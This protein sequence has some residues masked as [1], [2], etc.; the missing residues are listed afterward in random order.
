[1]ITFKLIRKIGKI[2]RGGAG[3]KEIMLGVVCGVILGFNPSVN[4]TLFLGILLTLLLNANISF[5]LF[6][7][8][9]GRLASLALAPAS[10]HL[11]IAII[12]DIGL[13][14]LFRTLANAPVTALM[15]L[16]VYA[17]VGGFPIALTIGIVLGAALGTSVIRIRKKMLEANQH[18]II[19]KT[20]GSRVSR[21]L[22]WLAFGK[23][24]LS[25]D[26]E[27][28]KKSPLFRKSGIIFVAALVVIGLLLELVLFDSL[29]RKGIETSISAMTGAE[30]NIAKVD[31]S[32]ANGKVDIQKLEA[33]DPDKPTHNLLQVDTL[34]ADLDIGELL[35]RA[36]TIDLLNGSILRFD[37][38]RAAPGAVYEKPQPPEK[39]PEDK[40][41]GILL[42]DYLAQAQKWKSY[43]EKTYELLKKFQEISAKKASEQPATKPGRLEKLATV[44]RMGYLKAAANL[45]TDRPEWL[46]RE[47]R[48]EQ[49]E[50]GDMPTQNLVAKEVS[51]QPSLSQQPTSLE[52]MPAAGGDP[53]LHVV[54]RFDDP[55]APHSIEFN[56]PG[57]SIGDA[58]ETS[59]SFP[60]D[61]QNGLADVSGGGHFSVDQLSIPFSIKVTNLKANVA[62]GKEILGMDSRTATEVFSS[63]EHLDLDGTFGGSLTAPSV[64]IDHEK[65]TANIKDALIA[66]GKKELADRANAEIDK[67]KEKITEQVGEEINKLFENE[68]AASAVDKAKNTLRNLNPF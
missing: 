23:S 21:F 57:I 41:P 61:V 12:H 7:L 58:I 13:E 3:R 34:V 60:M 50:M 2:L 45:R 59:D 9:L 38:E 33:T 22:L 64:T 65:L 46:V 20:F 40:E 55:S 16:N 25:L 8:V 48:I 62:E 39:R 26:E 11:G 14:N 43:A 67:A 68:D 24:R 17:V 1:M 6:G 32:L 42:E 44:E 19:G 36:Y 53:S 29:L 15:D 4:L 66:A 51:S 52:L 28:S 5:M 49:V 10:C 27:V 56:L 37:V 31:F 54:L 18:E 30:V 35:S 63:M 47:L